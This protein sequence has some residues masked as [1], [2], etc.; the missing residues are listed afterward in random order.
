MFCHCIGFDER[1][2]KAVVYITKIHTATRYL[3]DKDDDEFEYYDDKQ[4]LYTHIQIVPKNK[5]SPEQSLVLDI[6]LSLWNSGRRSFTVMDILATV[7]GKDIRKIGTITV[8]QAEEIENIIEVLRNIDIIINGSSRPLIDVAKKD[9]QPVEY[10]YRTGGDLIQWRISDNKPILLTSVPVYTYP[11]QWLNVYPSRGLTSA[12]AVKYVID[13]IVVGNAQKGHYK[14]RPS[15]NRIRLSTIMSKSGYP[16]D[17]SRGRWRCMMTRTEQILTACVD[18][19]DI[20]LKSYDVTYSG[21]S[22]RPNC[23]MFVLHYGKRDDDNG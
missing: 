17:S 22:R 6:V 1:V 2:S 8:Q 20:P 9:K 21:D 5:L 12:V 16:L 7:H 3:L 13:R 23:T 11:C 14:K 4:G 18:S 19:N 10:K 15:S